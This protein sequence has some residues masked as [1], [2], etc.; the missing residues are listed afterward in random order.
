MSNLNSKTSRD[1]IQTR[2]SLVRH[3]EQLTPGEVLLTPREMPKFVQEVI[4]LEEYPPSRA[5]RIRAIFRTKFLLSLIATL[6]FILL[7]IY[8]NHDLSKVRN[9]PF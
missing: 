8:L 3:K 7:V 4:L 5:R 6:L 9:A 2:Y 1:R